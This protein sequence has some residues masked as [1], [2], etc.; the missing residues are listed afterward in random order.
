MH[1][2]APDGRTE[3]M[4]RGLDNVGLYNF[5]NNII[6]SQS[7]RTAIYTNIK[8]NRKK[9]LL[10]ACSNYLN[11]CSVD[12]DG[13]TSDYSKHAVFAEILELREYIPEK[14]ADSETKENI[15]SY[16]FLLTRKY[17]LL[18]LHFDVKLNDF[19][20][21]SQVNL[22]ERNGMNI[23]EDITLLL[24]DR[25]RTLLFYGYKGILKYIHI[26]YD[27]YFNLS[28]IY[29]L[30]L[31][32]GLVIDII[33]LK[34]KQGRGSSGGRSG[35]AGEGKDQMNPF[36]LSTSKHS[37]DTH[38]E[39]AAEP[40]LTAKGDPHRSTTKKRGDHFTTDL[41]T[42]IKTEGRSNAP[43]GTIK[44]E[45]R[46]NVID[47]QYTTV[48]QIKRQYA[49]KTASLDHDV[50]VN[51]SF[52]RGEEW[53]TSNLGLNKRL[54]EWTCET[55]NQTQDGS[56]QMDPFMDSFF[57]D[58][59]SDDIHRGNNR[60]RKNNETFGSH[61]K[62]RKKQKSKVSATI[63]VLYDAKKK[64]STTYERY[65]RLIRLYSVND[66]QRPSS[67]SETSTSMNP[68]VKN[69]FSEYG[70]VQTSGTS[71]PQNSEVNS[72][73]E[74]KDAEK[75]IHLMYYKPVVVD[76]SINKLLCFARNKLMLVGFQFI[77]YVNL[78]TD[79]D[80][81]FFLSSELRTIRCIEHLNRNKFILSDDYGD[82]FILTCLY[83]SNPSSL[84][85]KND[86]SNAG[87]SPAVGPSMCFEMGEMREG[88]HQGHDVNDRVRRSISSCNNSYI[89]SCISSIT[90]QFIGTC[91]RSNVI[92]SLFPDIIF[93]GSQVSDSYLLL[94]HN[95]PVCE[96][97]D[98]NPVEPPSLP[99]HSDFDYLLSDRHVGGG[100]VDHNLYDENGGSLGG[101]LPRWDAT[102]GADEAN[103]ANTRFSHLEGISHHEALLKGDACSEHT[104]FPQSANESCGFS[105]RYQGNMLPHHSYDENVIR[106]RSEY[107]SVTCLESAGLNTE[108]GGALVHTKNPMKEK[109]KKKKKFFIEILSV[110]QNMGPILDFCVVKNKNDEK[111][112]ITCNSYGRTGCISIIRNGMKVDIISKLNFGKITNI[113]VVKYVI[114]LRKTSPRGTPGGEDRPGGGT[115]QKRHIHGDEKSRGDK[116]GSLNPDHLNQEQFPR[117]GI[118]HTHNE[119][120]GKK[121]PPLNFQ[122]FAYLNE[123]NSVEI[124]DINLC[125]L[126][127]YYFQNENEIEVLNYANFIYFHIFIICLSYGFHTKVVGVCRETPGERADRNRRGVPKG[128][129]SNFGEPPYRQ[130]KYHH[131]DEEEEDDDDNDNNGDNDDDDAAPF[132]HTNEYFPND[133]FFPCGRPSNKQNQICL[134][135]YKDVDVDLRSNT[136][137]FN[138]LKN[139]PYL[140]Q[141]TNRHINLLC[142]LSLK[143]V[144]QLEKDYIFR[145]CVYNDYF[146]VYCDRGIEIYSV[147]EKYLQLLHTHEVN[148]TI[149]SLVVYK[150]L[151]VCVLNSR[152]VVLFNIDHGALDRIRIAARR[153]LAD[154]AS[155]EEKKK[156]QQ[157]NEKKNHALNKA[158]NCDEKPNGRGIFVKANLY[159]PSLD[160]FV[161]ISDVQV[162]DLNDNVYLFVG[163]SNGVVEY[164]LLCA[165]R[166]GVEVAHVDD[167]SRGGG[168][169]GGKNG[170]SKGAKSGSK[171]RGQSKNHLAHSEGPPHRRRT[172][173]NLF[174][175]HKSYL[176]KK[177]ES[178]RCI[179][180]DELINREEKQPTQ[181]YK[182]KITDTMQKQ[183]KEKKYKRDLIRYMSET[184]SNVLPYFNN[185]KNVFTN[186][187]D[188]H[189]LCVRDQEDEILLDY[190]L[191]H[192]VYPE[193]DTFVGMED[194][195]Q[196]RHSGKVLA[197]E[198]DS[199]TGE[200]TRR[201]GGNG[202]QQGDAHTERKGNSIAHRS[203]C[204]KWIYPREGITQKDDRIAQQDE[205][206][207]PDDA[208][209][210]TQYSQ[211]VKCPGVPSRLTNKPFRR[212]L[213]GKSHHK[214]MSLHR[215][216]AKYY[217]QFFQIYGMSSEESSEEDVLSFRTFEMLDTKMKQ[218]RKL[219]HARET[220]NCGS[221]YC[222][223]RSSRSSKYIFRDDVRSCQGDT[224]NN[225]AGKRNHPA[226]KPTSGERKRTS[227][228]EHKPLSKTPTLPSASSDS[229][230]DG[231]DVSTSAVRKAIDLNHGMVSDHSASASTHDGR[232]RSSHGEA[233]LKVPRI[234]TSVDKMSAG[235][236]ERKGTKEEGW[237]GDR[238]SV[239]RETK[240][241]KDKL[242]PR[243][244]NLGGRKVCKE[245]ESSTDEQS[246][247]H[248]T[249]NES[250]CRFTNEQSDCHSTDIESDSP[251]TDGNQRRRPRSR[252][253]P[254]KTDINNEEHLLEEMKKNKTK[255]TKRELKQMK[256]KEEILSDI[257]QRKIKKQYNDVY[258]REKQMGSGKYSDVDAQVDAEI[259]SDASVCFK[260]LNNILFDEKMYLKK[261][262]VQSEKILLTKRRRIST[263]TKSPV[264]FKTFL[265]VQSE[266]NQIHMNMS[267]LTKRCNFLFVCCDKPIIIY[268]TLKKKLSISKL[269][270]RNVHLVDMFSD[271]NYLNP[272]H[273]FLS[274]KKKN[275]NNCYF[276][277]FDGYKV[278]IS[279]LNEMKKTFMERIPFHRTVEKIA[280]H[281]DTGL[282]ITACPVE[283]KHK[284]NQMMKQIVCFFDPFQNS[285]KYSYI[286]PSKFSVSSICIYELPP[287]P[288]PGRGHS[289]D[290]MNQMDRTNRDD[291]P[292]SPPVRTLICVGTANNN[293]RITEP[294]S[295]HIYVFVA[296]KKTNQ[297]EIKHIYTYNVNCGGITHLKQFR[298]KIVAAVNNT[299]VIL[300]IG[301]FLTNLGRYIYNSSKAIKIESND[302]FLEVASF[303]PSSWIM[304]LDVVKN[305]VLVGDIMTSVTLLSY[306]FENAI[307]DEVCRDY[308]N[309]WCT[310]VSALSENHFLVSD[311]ESNFLVLQKSNIKFNDEESFKLSLVSQFNHGS[312]VNKM[313][314]TSLR[315]LV[316]D[317][318]RRNEIVQKE[319][320]ILCASSEGSI[321]GL[322]PFSNFLQFKRALCIE[323][324]INDNISSLGNLS[325]SSYREYK[326]SLASKN[327][328][329][330]VDGEL[331]KMFFYL[332]FERQLKTYIYAKW[333]A[334]KLNCKL[335]SFEHFILDIENLCGLL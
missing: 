183:K 79:K 105:H 125:F 141:V 163:Y 1:S 248:S 111:E 157:Q 205:D 224:R 259:S 127:K 263:C 47:G 161:F 333:I 147:E 208:N 317:E 103:G 308:A 169:K 314:S 135:E 237:T 295:G 106:N 86:C 138:V 257:F 114:H 144:Y 81:N 196:W 235:D 188:L 146:Y 174:R 180:R 226:G 176:K 97:E 78:E 34:F 212:K 216:K 18:L 8:G 249:D 95:Y 265:K 140:V 320:S 318:E 307:L 73:R 113:F 62:A 112:I 52:S 28:H 165:D 271:F 272:F 139:F 12:K 93:L 279:Y 293:E 332:P 195:L 304:S 313:L 6:P 89:N 219:P 187:S 185:E 251:P 322:I 46:S 330:V 204:K 298:D 23:E 255:L 61:H 213:N 184:H 121:K 31:D 19:V 244:A 96:Y 115:L 20:T 11:V 4:K 152:E 116:N 45:S 311:M 123:K 220:P 223:G 43:D 158:L 17:N 168:K 292:V 258:V 88:I 254:H 122:A 36:Q 33:F 76:S 117:N 299:V 87:I 269:S 246:D 66:E 94:M 108:E 286:I 217:F 38:D 234:S 261:Y 221:S 71:Y 202:P 211:Y 75:C 278:C 233:K 227:W 25:N 276:I 9:Y 134:C 290:E 126:N 274:F 250:D 110:I 148:E 124:K 331:F 118:F 200:S 190:D 305:Y 143:M 55:E 120:K 177:E 32:E 107:A 13:Y 48:E 164:F 130:K 267:N 282:L 133:Y 326:V 181:S 197:E 300:D 222:D 65:I 14:L 35:G 129:T 149:S 49:D 132:N 51:G 178:L 57:A 7:I 240:K 327:C 194:I 90:L 64:E 26:D 328:K 283:E 24:D 170:A 182:I 83:E 284:T 210:F 193:S 247:C 241:G 256:E 230:A 203:N 175:L 68:R 191:F 92:V 209:Q 160:Y 154:G 136:I 159:T 50:S 58:S 27:D 264:R 172:H 30:R 296:K 77:S 82:L 189:S 40:N 232:R 186:L 268:S 252:G 277:F 270:I 316:D 173:D 201:G 145:F 321:S 99:T 303:T 218:R 179:Y 44:Q 100:A 5:Y 306:D 329:G 324:A 243:N 289:M 69:G 128:A 297:F 56:P 155:L 231:N 288:S 22:H 72:T 245:E 262:V 21:I 91:S 2:S 162:L 15:K 206:N 137:H 142:C 54:S 70:Y 171:K 101:Q 266:K 323:I 63:C 236:P 207:P 198:A 59:F 285:F 37:T 3:D 41:R 74:P 167:Q 310:S 291:R 301:N 153:S 166:R 102:N 39:Y 156:G 315:N 151:M 225:V 53:G 104:L 325:H 280:Y 199:G 281:D 238:T 131:Y 119:E 29:T 312:V 16:V 42:D 214:E 192:H 228:K 273:N 319:R 215:K 302:A 80:R 150:S 98:Y 67:L 242:H 84:R 10:Y 335:G 109:K 239:T 229:N 334:K 85:M 275:Q 309:I 260:N 60:S 253:A 294:C 287:S